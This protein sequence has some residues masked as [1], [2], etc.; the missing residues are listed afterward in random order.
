MLTQVQAAFE[1]QPPETVVFVIKGRTWG[2]GLNFLA[3]TLKRS[4]RHFDYWLT[5]CDD[6]VPHPGWFE[7]ARA[8]V[9]AGE[10][11]AQRYF[12][13]GGFPLHDFDDAEDGTE[14]PW[15]R[16]YLLTPELYERVGPFL[17]ATWYVDFD[18]SE[19]LSAAGIPIVA[20]DGYTFTHLDGDRD[21]HTAVVDDQ[22][23]RLWEASREARGVA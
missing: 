17:D 18:Y 8:V 20:C 14:L 7:A 22:E 19:R 5:C 12:T 13:R 3:E 9:D 1:S 6:T 15:S 2:S 16:G 21:W 11:P 23:R 4:P 10:M